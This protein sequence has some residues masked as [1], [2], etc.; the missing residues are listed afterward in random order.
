MLMFRAL[1]LLACGLALA[2][3]APARGL[4]GSCPAGE[5]GDAPPRIF[6][7][8][9]RVAALRAAAETDATVAAWT[10]RIVQ[11]AQALDVS[12]LPALER[13]WWEADR[14][15]PWAD[16]YP[17]IFH[18]TWVVPA[19]WATAARQCAWAGTLRPE[20]DLAAKARQ[21]LLP[22]ADFSFE[23]EHYDVGMNYTIWAVTAL[24]AY[25]LLYESLTP[26]ERQ[27]LDAFCQ[28]FVAAVRKNDE[29][30]IEHEPGGELNNHYA[31]HKLA[32]VAGGLFTRQLDLVEQALDGPKGI[33]FLIQHGFTDEGLWVEGSIPYQ[34][35]ATAPLVQA[36]ELLENAGYPRTLFEHESGDGHT[37]RGAYDALLPLLFPDRTL[38]TIGDCYGRRPPLGKGA[39]WEI[40]CRRFRDPQYGWLLQ[41]LPERSPDAL[42]SGRP[43]L[44]V[45]APPAQVSRLWPEHGY[46]ALRS[47]EGADYWTG[48]GWTL[49]ATYSHNR[50]HENLDRLSVIL[51]GDGHL[52][53]PDCEA[54]P[55]AEHSF[56]ARAQ[57]ELNRQTLCHNTLLVDGHS[58]HFPGRPLE[59]VEYRTRPAAKRVSIGDLTG[60]LYPDVR[61][62]RTCVV[63]A[64]YVLDFFQVRAA[65][66]RTLDWLLHINGQSV[67]RAQTQAPQPASLPDEVPWN[68]LQSPER[69]TRS[70]TFWETFQ[71]GAGTFRVDLLCSAPQEILACGFPR[72]EQDRS[73]VIPMRILRSQQAEGWY[74]AVYRSGTHVEEPL[75]VDVA[76]GALRHWQITI[77]LAGRRYLHRIPQFE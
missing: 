22:L 74:A 59:L 48:R 36:A 10:E 16:T 43:D 17:Q 57:R 29:Y 2:T 60:Q 35:A 68:Y 42:L 32:F 9:D 14:E 12:A 49:F 75:Q 65:A 24:E 51:F 54:V 28:R 31:W 30:W 4:P 15:K 53:L 13:A 66:P 41:S 8:L 39:D 76:A 19:R 34:L 1:T 47:V 3:P 67:A 69:W 55:A 40:L 58:Q 73:Q 11:E 64:E 61:Q 18:H 46:V 72:D 26:A 5:A 44:P 25:E 70:D 20:T 6:A 50:V 7:P 77:Q 56:S 63:R 45:A 71:E 37:L 27:K 33:L 62:L 21:V 52:W 23:F 38:P